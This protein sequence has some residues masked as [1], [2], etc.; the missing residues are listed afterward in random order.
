MKIEIDMMNELSLKGQ[1]EAVQNYIFENTVSG[2][3]RKWTKYKK[4]T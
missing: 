4:D 3:I 1:M 2:D